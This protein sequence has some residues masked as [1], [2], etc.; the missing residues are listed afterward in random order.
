MFIKIYRDFLKCESKLRNFRKE[1]FRV[2]RIQ[3]KVC[4]INIDYPWSTSWMIEYYGFIKNY[5]I[6]KD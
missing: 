1:R 2:Y 5:G 6:F 3:T 4:K